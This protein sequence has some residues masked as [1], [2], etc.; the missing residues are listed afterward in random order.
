MLDRK[1]MLE[2]NVVDIISSV[3][4]WLVKMYLDKITNDWLLFI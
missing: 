1:K 2:S 3:E 4:I